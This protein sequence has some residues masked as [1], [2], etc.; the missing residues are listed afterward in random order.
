MFKIQGEVRISEQIL[1]ALRTQFGHLKSILSWSIEN[2]LRVLLLSKISRNLVEFR[3]YKTSCEF[4]I[5][6]I[7]IEFPMKSFNCN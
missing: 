3:L 4:I 6:Q 1:N 7:E 2:L 5:F